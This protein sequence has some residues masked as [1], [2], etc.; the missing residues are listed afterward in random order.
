MKAN[1]KNAIIVM[2]FTGAYNMEDFAGNPHFVHLDGTGIR[3]TD[4]YC[5]LE[6]AEKIKQLISPFGPEGIHFIDSGDFHYITKFWT[7]KVK[8]PFSLILFDHH[9]DMQ[10][11]LIEDMLSCGN[12]VKDMIACN[13]FLKQVLLLG[14]PK[15]AERKIPKAYRHKVKLYD[16]EEMH[17]LLFSGHSIPVEDPVYISIDKDVLDARSAVTNWDQGTLSLDDL[18]KALYAFLTEK[19]VIGIDICGEYSMIQ[20]LF[21]EKRGAMIDNRANASLLAVIKESGIGEGSAL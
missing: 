9:T 19:K 1:D 3:G 14:I 18:Q 10:P 7:D 12:W 21:D 11:S 2:N 16:V 5:S 17:D 20:D 6:G 15:N 8:T 13:A 4:C